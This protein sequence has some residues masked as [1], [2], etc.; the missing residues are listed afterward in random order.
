MSDP[1][2]VIEQHRVFAVIRTGTADEAV[3]AAEAC[4][5]GGVRLL[6]ITL[7]VPGALGAVERLLRHPEALVGVGSVVEPGQARAAADAG[8]RFVVSPHFDPDILAETK[9]RGLLSSMGGVT[10]TE[11][12]TCH[13]AGVDVT[14]IFPATAFGPGYLKALREPLPFLRL[15]PT[16]GVDEGNLTAWLDAG[17]V[18]V[19]MGGSLVDKKAVAAGDWGA[20]EEKARRVVAAVAAWRSR[21]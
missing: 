7:T 10:A 20:V 6:E 1:R 11:V 21:G 16:G 8:A 2:A 14:K 15:M 13:R 19:G 9:A 5:R 18:A 3:S 4:L 17:A 12:V